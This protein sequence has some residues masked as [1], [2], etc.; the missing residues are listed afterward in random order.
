MQASGGEVVIGGELSGDVP[1][2]EKIGLQGSPP[3]WRRRRKI[4]HIRGIQLPQ[5]AGDLAAPATGDLRQPRNPAEHLLRLSLVRDREQAGDRDRLRRGDRIDPVRAGQLHRTGCAQ[6]ERSLAG[7][8]VIENIAIRDNP[9]RPGRGTIL[10]VQ[11]GKQG[12]R[13]HD[14][15]R[16]RPRRHNHL[17][18]LRDRNTERPGE[19]ADR[20]LHQVTGRGCRQQGK[21]GCADGQCSRG[22]VRACLQLLPPLALA[23]RDQENLQPAR[24]V[25]GRGAQ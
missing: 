1:F 15:D 7:Q 9:D 13:V 21:P 10:A 8:E 23:A 5:P 17:D 20:C 19:R 24:V 14:Q 16:Y 11:D 22:R 2:G 18:L 4:R 25:A 3:A 6:P 12:R